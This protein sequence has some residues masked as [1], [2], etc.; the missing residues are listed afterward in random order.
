[1]FF[2]YYIHKADTQMVKEIFDNKINDD[3]LIEI[4]I[5]VHFPTITDWSE[6]A[7]VEG[8]IQLKDAYYNYVKL[9][10]TRDTM[11]FVCL[12]NTTKTRLVN[13]NV[14]T[15]KEIS[16]V[17]VSK[18]A[19]DP[20]VKKVNTVSE[21]HLQAFKYQYAE[22]AKALQRDNRTYSY[23]LD[24]PFIDSPGKPPNSIS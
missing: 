15:A 24:E 18:K 20:L 17:P 14:I 9:K 21:Y 3:K 16:D 8:Q 22:F 12:P 6:Y 23:Q 2:Q 11:Y 7:V 13:A 10:V 19:H 1:L 4:K 5:P